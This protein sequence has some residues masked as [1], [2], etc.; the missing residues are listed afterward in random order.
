MTCSFHLAKLSLY[1]IYWRPDLCMFSQNVVD[2]HCLQSNWHVLINPYFFLWKYVKIFFH[3]GGCFSCFAS[4]LQNNF[5][6][7]RDPIPL[8]QSDSVLH[9][10]FKSRCLVPSLP[11]SNS[12]QFVYN[13]DLLFFSAAVTVIWAFVIR[14][15]VCFTCFWLDGW[16]CCWWVGGHPW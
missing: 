13:S 11:K 3:T 6:S 2:L 15:D 16:G 4:N 10:S 8:R 12:H 14:L 1:S 5:P 7:G 9:V